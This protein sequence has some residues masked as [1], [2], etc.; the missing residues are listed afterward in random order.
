MS[1]R[2]K[3][4]VDFKF[5][6]PALFVFLVFRKSALVKSGSSSEDPPAIQSFVISCSL[7]K[8]LHPPHMLECLPF[9]SG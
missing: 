8:I 6:P 4:N 2:Y 7:V 3:K 9:W 1:C 5:Q